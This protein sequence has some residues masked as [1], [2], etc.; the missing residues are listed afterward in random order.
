VREGITKDPSFLYGTTSMGNQ[1]AH[2]KAQQSMIRSSANR[3]KNLMF[4]SDFSP[5]N[6][7][8]NLAKGKRS[9][10]FIYPIVYNREQGS[11]FK[12]NLGNS[13][14]YLTFSK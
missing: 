4:K 7:Y 11:P 13:K 2:W 14:T 5:N 10:G 9:N 6:G 1:A 12:P 3:T 8:L